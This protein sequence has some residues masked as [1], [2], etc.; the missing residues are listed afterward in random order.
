M[1]G[2]QAVRKVAKI[3][4]REHNTL[5]VIEQGSSECPFQLL[6]AKEIR[7]SEEL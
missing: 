5:P 3:S 6:E 2:R 1:E 4:V 7:N